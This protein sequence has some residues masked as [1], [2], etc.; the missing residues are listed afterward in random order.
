MDLYI[1]NL[2]KDNSKK[3]FEAIENLYTKITPQGNIISKSSSEKLANIMIIENIIKSGLYDCDIIN[4]EGKNILTDLIF[5]CKWNYVY[6]YKLGKQHIIPLTILLAK[7]KA[8]NI[9]KFRID[10]C[11]HVVEYV[12]KFMLQYNGESQDDLSPKPIDILLNNDISLDDGITQFTKLLIEL[13]DFPNINLVVMRNAKSIL[14]LVIVIEKRNETLAHYI[15]TNGVYKSR[16][17]LLLVYSRL[18]NNNKQI[19]NN[20]E[21]FITNEDW[22]KELCLYIPYLSNTG[23]TEKTLPALKQKAINENMYSVI[24]ALKSYESIL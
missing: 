9:D 1:N 12:A 23:V 4:K 20:L 13:I 22:V 16:L 14:I 24:D 11:F 21:K 10:N 6:G 7:N 3:V 18:I 8:F 5:T 17:P 19:N 2:K 15:L